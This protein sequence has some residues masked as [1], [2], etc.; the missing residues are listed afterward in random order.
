M[1]VPRGKEMFLGENRG[2]LRKFARDVIDSGADAV[3]GHGPHI[4]RGMEVYKNRLIAYSLG[5]FATYGRF[6]LKGQKKLGA[7]L[8]LKLDANGQF[9]NGK[10]FPTLQKGRGVPFSDPDKKAIGFIRQLSKSDFGKTSIQIDEEGNIQK[11]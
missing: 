9:I 5:N 8:E 10:V 1:T 6:S 2:H 3:I 11:P 4:L 7:I